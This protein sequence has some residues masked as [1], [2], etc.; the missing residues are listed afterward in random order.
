MSETKRGSAGGQKMAIIQKE[1]AR[2]RIDEYNKI[3]NT[4]QYCGKPILASYNK[5]LYATKRKK[6][7]NHT[8]ASMYNKKYNLK[9]VNVKSKTL[10]DKYSDNELLNIYQNSNSLKEFSEKLGYKRPI[11]YNTSV[12]N[13][14][15]KSIGIDL[16]KFKIDKDD[17]ESCTKGYLF[18]E[19]KNWTY[20][21]VAIQKVAK[22]NYILSSKPKQCIVCGYNKHYEVAHIK[23]VSDFG[24]D[25]LISEIDNINNLIALCPNHHWEYDNNGLDIQQYL[26]KLD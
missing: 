26:D 19:K 23:A 8:C 17:I 15:F 25:V 22:R 5:N 13:S 2:K 14:R 11:K 1:Q 6:F 7:C 10:L 16:D 24:D 18:K 3:P 12:I 21:R 20:A 4:C 9:K